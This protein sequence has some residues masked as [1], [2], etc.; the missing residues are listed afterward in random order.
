[1]SSY[2]FCYLKKQKPEC[3]N[4]CRREIYDLVGCTINIR[5]KLI[6]GAI[7]FE[8]VFVIPFFEPSS[9]LCGTPEA[10]IV[11]S[12]SQRKNEEMLQGHVLSLPAAVYPLFLLFFSTNFPD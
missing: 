5:N 8:K 4:I 2:F 9:M 1:M 6:S 11:E 7:L 3:E 12:A 10:I